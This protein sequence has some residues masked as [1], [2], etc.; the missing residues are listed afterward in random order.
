[1]TNP[2]I[3][4]HLTPPC[5][6]EAVVSYLN[7]VV[8]LYVVSAAKR[9]TRSCTSVSRNKLEDVVLGGVVVIL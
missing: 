9:R 6:G 8:L 2:V 1:M 3:P 4:L 5:L 7:L